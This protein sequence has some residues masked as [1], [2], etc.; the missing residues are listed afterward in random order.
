[1]RLRLMEMNPARNA[2][3]YLIT[4]TTMTIASKLHKPS[5]RRDESLHEVRSVE[6]SDVQEAK[7]GSS[8]LTAPPSLAA[9]TSPGSFHFLSE[10]HRPLQGTV[11]E[12]S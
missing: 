2:P 12:R 10:L 7:A 1:V 5:F 9:R 6:C 3:K 8:G 4:M 11:G